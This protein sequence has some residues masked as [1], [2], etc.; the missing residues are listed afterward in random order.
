MK[1]ATWNVNSLKMRLPHVLDWLNQSKTDILCLQE[2]K[3]TDDLFPIEA[4]GNSGFGAVWSGQKTYNGVAIVYR[5]DKFGEPESVQKNI[6]TFPDEQKR[7]IASTFKTESGNIRIVCGYF[8][9][10]S[11]VGSDKFAY[12]LAWLEAL[13]HW[14]KNQLSEY[15]QLALLGD[16]NIA[17]D[18]RDVWDP[19]GWEGNILVSPQER[20]AFSDLLSLGLS[21]SFRLFEQPEKRY[22]WW[23]YRM[24]GFQKNHG[25]RIDHILVSDALKSKVKAVDI[26]KVPRKWPK[27][28]DH[29]PYWIESVYGRTMYTRW[30]SELTSLLEPSYGT[31]SLKIGNLE[32]HVL[33]SDEQ[34]ALLEVAPKLDSLI[35]EGKV[36]KYSKKST[37][38]L[39][40]AG[41]TLVFGKHVRFH[42]KAFGLRFRYFVQPSRSFWTAVVAKK[43][44]EAG[45]GTPKVLA[46]GERRTLQLISDSYIITEALSDANTADTVLRSQPNSYELLQ[47]AGRLLR[48]LHDAG[49]AHGDIKLANFYVQ[50]D[51]MGFW[52]LDSAMV[53]SGQTPQKWIIRDLG[54]LLS[55]FILTVDDMPQTQDYFRNAPEIARVL[56]EAYGIDVQ[57]FLPSY[58]SYWLKKI[59]LKHDFG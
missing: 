48:R 51:S 52:D 53:F 16:F 13:N 37:A 47:N 38:S 27:P 18:D 25:L 7:L 6:P 28:S 55:S 41:E 40:K 2:L 39:F 43:L 58:Y 42:Q 5:K 59:K 24:L 44:E 33:P 17:P 15:S 9:N 49:M 32:Y 10:G 3:M 22:T 57:T 1:I 34:V 8:P 29:T 35:E 31:K 4:L 19:K 26:D 12:K 50:G 46:V 56:A 21:D 45:L 36:Q 54:R 30:S 23:D 20:Q 14:L 11:E